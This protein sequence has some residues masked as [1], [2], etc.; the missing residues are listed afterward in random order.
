LPI[1]HAL[2]KTGENRDPNLTTVQKRDNCKKFAQ[3]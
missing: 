2:I 3:G 1:E